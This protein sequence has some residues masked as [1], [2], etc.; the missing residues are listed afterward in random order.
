VRLATDADPYGE[1]NLTGCVKRKFLTV[2]KPSFG[3]GLRRIYTCQTDTHP[4]C[5][6]IFDDWLRGCQAAP[7]AG[8]TGV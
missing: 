6:S 3:E 1:S 4:L 2:D 8:M 7:T 5:P